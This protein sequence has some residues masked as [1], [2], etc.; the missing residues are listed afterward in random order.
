M[1]TISS[2]S[3]LGAASKVMNTMTTIIILAYSRHHTVLGNYSY[4]NQGIL[5]NITIN[6]LH[7]RA[8]LAVALPS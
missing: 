5:L 8:A 2:S 3:I 7:A 4:G 6:K 1:V